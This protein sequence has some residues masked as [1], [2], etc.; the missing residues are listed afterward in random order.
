[1]VHVPDDILMAFVDGELSEKE[2]HWLEGMLAA[3][4]QLRRR[5]EPFAVTR[6]A[7]PV[8]FSAPLHEPVPDRLVDAVLD[9]GLPNRTGPLPRGASAGSTGLQAF[10]ERWF[11]APARLSSGFSYAG[12]LLVGIATGWLVGGLM[13]GSGNDVVKSRGGQMIADGRLQEALEHLP[14]GSIAGSLGKSVAVR[15]VATFRGEEG[16]ICRQYLGTQGQ[17]RGFAGLACRDE[18]GL[19]RVKLHSELPPSETV[20]LE[21]GAAMPASHDVGRA[22]D[23]M[24]IA[25][26]IDAAAREL[27]GG[28]RLAPADEDYFIKKG[29]DAPA[30]AVPAP[31]P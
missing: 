27:T 24:A 13:A 21:G 22:A 29:W 10:M 6:A 18:G 25:P 12:M 19:W 11:P 14:Q 17:E 4:P 31:Q 2:V 15:P 20:T 26:V 3:D 1:M 9:T 28:N 8:V 16:Q 30:R 5:L 7:L 23:S